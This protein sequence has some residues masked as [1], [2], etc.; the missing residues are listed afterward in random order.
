MGGNGSLAR[1]A[2]WRSN[3]VSADWPRAEQWNSFIHCVLYVPMD[4]P[5][6]NM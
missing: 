6:Q 5:W 2:F 4:E 3:H 1:R